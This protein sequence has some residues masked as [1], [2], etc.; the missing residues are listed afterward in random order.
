MTRHCRSC[1]DPFTGESWKTLCWAC[2]RQHRD[3]REAERERAWW[4][5]YRAGVQAAARVVPTVGLDRELLDQ[6][7]RLCH[8]DR[9]PVER[10]AIANQVTAQ[11]LELRAQV[12]A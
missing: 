2:W 12:A 6:A 11:L 1:G 3:T 10:A 8:P 5:G 7:V 9:H 4:D